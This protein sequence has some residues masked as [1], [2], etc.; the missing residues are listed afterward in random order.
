VVAAAVAR[1]GA[2]ANRHSG[3]AGGDDDESGSE[4]HEIDIKSQRAMERDAERLGENN[5]RISESHSAAHPFLSALST[6]RIF[7]AMLACLVATEPLL[8]WLNNADP[9]ALQLALFVIF[10]LLWLATLY[11]WYIVRLKEQLVALRARGYSASERGAWPLSVTA[12]L[13]FA[14]FLLRTTVAIVQSRAD[15]PSSALALSTTA[16]SFVCIVAAGIFTE[17]HARVYILHN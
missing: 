1:T 10:T 3:G 5:G 6:L 8:L 4:F 16:V 12:V 13:M 2:A 11:H 14:A 17:R 9:V 15:E 7:L